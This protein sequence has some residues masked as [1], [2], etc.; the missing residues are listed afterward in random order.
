[1]AVKREKIGIFLDRDG[2]ISEE[3]GYI[4]N[5]EKFSL[6]NFSPRAIKKLNVLG[7]KVIVV[8]NQAGIAKGLYTEETLHSIHK[9]MI[10][11]LEKEGAHIDD[12]YYCPHHSDGKIKAYS[13]NCECRKPKSGMIVKASKKFNFNLKHSFI[14][15]DKIIDLEAGSR[16]GSRSIL[17]LT[18]HGRDSLK[19]INNENK[20]EKPDFIAENLLEASEII[21]REIM[22]K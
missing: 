16:L 2:T 20:S 18:G 11:Q 22:G 19:K 1:V 14:V 5:V 3:I 7:V 10:E 17:V 4:D 15:G 21:C 12:I 6:Y 8:T 9:K 13:I